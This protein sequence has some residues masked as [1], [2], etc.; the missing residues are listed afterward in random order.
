MNNGDPI[1]RIKKP[2]YYSDRGVDKARRH[3]GQ[4]HSEPS[5]KHRLNEG[6]P[7]SIHSRRW[8]DQIQ[9]KWIAGWALQIGGKASRSARRLVGSV[10]PIRQ[11]RIR[12]SLIAGCVG[13]AERS[14]GGKMKKRQ[15]RSGRRD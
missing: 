5:A 9:E 15:A 7:R 12:Q 1:E 13:I 6:D 2:R 11:Q 14:G 3:Q 4:K 8:A 10:R